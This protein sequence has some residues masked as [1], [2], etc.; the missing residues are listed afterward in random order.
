VKIRYNNPHSQVANREQILKTYP[1]SFNE[2]HP[3]F[4][5]RH[6]ENGAGRMLIETWQ[7]V[8]I[9]LPPRGSAGW[10]AARKAQSAPAATDRAR[11]TWK[12]GK[13]SISER[14]F[15]SAK[16]SR[17]NCSSFFFDGDENEIRVH[18]HLVG[19]EGYSFIHQH[20]DGVYG[21]ETIPAEILAQ[22]RAAKKTERP[23][24]TD[25]EAAYYKTSRPDPTDGKPFSAAQLAAAGIVK[26]WG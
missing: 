9:P 6:I 15:I 22:Y 14:V 17:E 5:V 25:S 11:V 8:E 24:I 20:D 21:P 18:G 4:G 1:N 16:C 19:L 23:Q 10:L 7:A 12:V 26:T 13:A 3:D 2:S